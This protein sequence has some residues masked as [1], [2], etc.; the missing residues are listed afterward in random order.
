MRLE[1][2]VSP[3]ATTTWP[4]LNVGAPAA[5]VL[6]RLHL[7]EHAHD[8]AV[9]RVGFFDHHDRVGAVGHRRAGR[10]FDA[11]AVAH[12]QRRHLARVERPDSRQRPRSC[13]R[14]APCVSRARTA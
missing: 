11:L 8:V 4:G 2:S 6:L 1:F 7:G 9:I 5:D 10:N 14:D 12:R 3:A 13:D